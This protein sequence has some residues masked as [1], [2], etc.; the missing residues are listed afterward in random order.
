MKMLAI[1]KGPTTDAMKSRRITGITAHNLKHPSL[2][3]KNST[4]TLKCLSF[5]T[6][7]YVLDIFYQPTY[8]IDLTHAELNLT[9]KDTQ[10]K[11]N[12]STHSLIHSLTH[13]P[14][15]MYN[16]TGNVHITYH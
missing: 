13:S 9:H 15:N 5:L 10:T 6:I 7:N 2:K 1:P 4:V 11:M 8:A 16:K 12:M 3:E 14:N